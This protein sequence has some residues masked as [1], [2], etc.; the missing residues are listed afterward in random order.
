MDVWLTMT[1]EQINA[2]LQL[3]LASPLP[4]YQPAVM[5]RILI[6]ELKL[7][8]GI[9]E[10]STAVLL[11][12]TALLMRQGVAMQVECTLSQAMRR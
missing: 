6:D 11:G 7:M 12:V 5:A 10:E 1:G 3:M 9:T 2:R 4:E 8:P